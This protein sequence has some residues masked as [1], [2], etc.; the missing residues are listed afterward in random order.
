MFEQLNYFISF[1]IY[2]GAGRGLLSNV[3]MSTATDLDSPKL[4]HHI[5]FSYAISDWFIENEKLEV[6]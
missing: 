1:T 3:Q 2:C 6:L 5:S 4:V